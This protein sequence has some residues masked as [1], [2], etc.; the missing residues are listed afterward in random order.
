MRTSLLPAPTAT[1]VVEPMPPTSVTPHHIRPHELQMEPSPFAKGSGGA[2]YRAEYSGKWFAVKAMLPAP[3]TTAAHG[4]TM[5]ADILIEM[6]MLCKLHH[7]NIVSLIGVCWWDLQAP[8]LVLELCDTTLENK[9]AGRAI[10]SDLARLKYATQL[11]RALDYLHSQHIIHRDVKPANV[12]V[13]FDDRIKLADFGLARTV[14]QTTAGQRAM[15]GETGSYRYMA[16]EILAHAAHY[17][18]AVDVYSCG[19]ILY[20]LFSGQRPFIEFKDPVLAARAA[21]GGHRPN[22]LDVKHAK[23]REIMS[24]A[25]ES[26]SS[27]RPATKSLLASLEHSLAEET[28]PHSPFH[29]MW[30]RLP[31]VSPRQR[32]ASS[33][34]PSSMMSKLVL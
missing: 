16:P 25:W 23:V 13:S 28:A 18:S 9:L 15:S 33:S 1:P 8:V 6:D 7:P 21:L 22:P 12:L 10:T 11:T 31:S 17:H 27:H 3:T 19:L 30:S 32:P 5:V 26:D 14:P 29:K 4:K 24:K 2:I 20:Y 34:P